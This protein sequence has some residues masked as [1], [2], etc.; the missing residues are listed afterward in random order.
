[1][2]GV[3]LREAGRAPASAACMLALTGPGRVGLV[4]DVRA[5]STAKRVMVASV[6]E[7]ERGKK[8]AG[9]H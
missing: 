4:G 7:F 6:S 2:L 8:N 1:M 5:P 9:H 3:S